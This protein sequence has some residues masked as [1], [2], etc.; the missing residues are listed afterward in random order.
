MTRELCKLFKAAKM[1]KTMKQVIV[2]ENNLLEIIETSIPACGPG[3]VLVKVHYSGLCGSDIPRIF[4]DGAHYY[5]VTLGHEF[6]G[7]IMAVGFLVTKV[8]PGQ[9]ICCIPLVPDFSMP[10][11]ERGFYSLGKGYTFVGSRLPGGN[12]EY[13]VMPESSCYLLPA[14]VNAKQ[15]A[16][17]EPVT[18]GIH[19]ILLAGGCENKNVVII[20][21]GT[22]GLLALQSAKAMGAKTVTAIDI[23]EE[24]L[25]LAMTLG[26]DYV[27]NASDEDFIS[28][29][30]HHQEIRF[31]QL[32]L[33]TAGAPQTVKTA[34]AF[35]GPRAQLALVGTLHRDLLLG[36][37]EYEQIL[38]KELVLYG[39]WMNYSAPFPGKEWSITADLFI[40]NQMN[41]DA[42]ISSDTGVEEYV[43]QVMALAGGPAN[44]KILLHWG[45]GK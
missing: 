14:G 38:R 22:I 21:A 24:K 5:P 40:N 7:E 27:A 4:H 30:P 1:N 26:A 12:A 32:I 35:A 17:F 3:D 33:E 6:A 25:A 13:V 37:Q 19:P 45:E 18:V 31:D 29:F 11:C 2:K 10:E 23:N 43:R 9:M 41:I 36:F 28:R 44:G 16:F 15:G 8:R 20:G 34:L 39:S 42:I